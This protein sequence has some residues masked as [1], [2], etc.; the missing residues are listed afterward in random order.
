MT[1]TRFAAAAEAREHVV[2]R[3]QHWTADRPTLIH[4]VAGWL[5]S[6]TPDKAP[7]ACVETPE[8]AKET[9]DWPSYNYIYT[10]AGIDVKAAHVYGD[11]GTSAEAL[12]RL[13][14]APGSIVDA[15]HDEI[16][17]ECLE[18]GGVV[19]HAAALAAAYEA[20]GRPKDAAAV[21]KHPRVRAAEQ[22]AAEQAAAQEAEAQRASTA[23]SGR[24]GAMTDIAVDDAT[25]EETRQIRKRIHSAF[26]VN[27]TGG[28]LTVCATKHG[29]L[30]LLAPG[31]TTIP[32]DALAVPVEN[33]HIV[34]NRVV[35]V[36]WQESAD[37]RDVRGVHQAFQGRRLSKE[38]AGRHNA[39]VI[40]RVLKREAAAAKLQALLSVERTEQEGV[41]IGSIEIEAA[42]R[43]GD[44]GGYG[45]RYYLTPA[46]HLVRTRSQYDWPVVIHMSAE[47]VKPTVIAT[48]LNIPR[49]AVPPTP[50]Q[51]P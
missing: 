19:A 8:G 6:A 17:P 21:R 39:R 37:E 16:G 1:K 29:R 11:A 27:E 38:N 4:G 20:N 45:I 24:L 40:R 5:E 12:V 22:A 13:P 46:N 49:N 25:E 14:L 35:K 18:R 7:S 10:P 34:P 28:A 44:A 51:R 3:R 31:R 41:P 30:G 33:D 48:G 9:G 42:N 26:R 15:L 43:T 2:L 50:Q 32:A 23:E 36:H 47:P